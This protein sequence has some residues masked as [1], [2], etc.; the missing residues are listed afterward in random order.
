MLLVGVGFEI[1]VVNAVGER[2]MVDGQ[3]A[4]FVFGRDAKVRRIRIA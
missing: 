1:G 3:H 4:V 2:G